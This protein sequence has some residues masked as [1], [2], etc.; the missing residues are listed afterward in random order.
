MILDEP[1]AFL[2]VES[3]AVVMT[4]LRNLAHETGRSV[5]ATSHDIELVLRIADEVWMIA[6][7]RSIMTGAPEDL[8]LTGAMDKVFPRHV[9]RF[10]LE[11][12]GFRLP[13]PTGTDIAVSG[14]GTSAVWT[15]RALERAGM[16]VRS[17]TADGGTTDPAAPEAPVVAPPGEDGRWMLQDDPGGGA[18][19]Q[20]DSIADLVEYLRSTKDGTDHG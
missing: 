18:S 9:M 13:Q 11:T 5:I 3:R 20:F 10:D 2:D 15:A 4:T 6:P 17:V 16:R 14:G 12:G 8:V 19:K 1:T 7:D